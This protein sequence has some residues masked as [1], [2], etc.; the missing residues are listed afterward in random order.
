MR[1]FFYKDPTVKKGVNGVTV[2]ADNLQDANKKV[3]D[4][5]PLWWPKLQL[6][7]SCTLAEPTVGKFED[8]PNDVLVSAVNSATR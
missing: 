6:H 7:F 5:Y 3:G 1:A 8:L 4:Q 2:F